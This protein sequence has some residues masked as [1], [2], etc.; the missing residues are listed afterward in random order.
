MAGL[1]RLDLI[2][3]ACPNRKLGSKEVTLVK[4]WNN[5]HTPDITF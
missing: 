5:V 2:T 1:V 4:K 3:L